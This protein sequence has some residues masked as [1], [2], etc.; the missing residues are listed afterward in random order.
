VYSE[1]DLNDQ[2][3]EAISESGLNPNIDEH[4]SGIR[5]AGNQKRIDLR[6]RLFCIA[7]T[8]RIGLTF[9]PRNERNSL[10]IHGIRLINKIIDA[11]QLTDLEYNVYFDEGITNQS[12]FDNNQELIAKLNLNLNQDSKKVKGI[13]LA[14]LLAHTS[15]MMLKEALGLIK[16]SIKAGNN[17]GYDPETMIEI[18]FLMWASIRYLFFQSQDG[19]D[20]EHAFVGYTNV[21]DYGLLISDSFNKEL[22]EVI[23]CRFSTNYLGCIH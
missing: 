14:D 1:N 9:V 12:D 17:S 6:D 11:N 3:T 13:Q 15:S 4:K 21:E 20:P 18:G 10:F 7:S 5:I 23:R 2:I 16:K 19:V 22:E 8:T